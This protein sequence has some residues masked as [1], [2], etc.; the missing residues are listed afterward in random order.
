MGTIHMIEASKHIDL[1]NRIWEE[2]RM[3]RQMNEVL[4][5]QS[6]GK[7]PRQT[8]FEPGSITFTKA[9]LERVQHP[10][11]NPLVIQLRMNGYDV[12]KILVN[13]GSSIEMMYY[14]LF[15]QLKLSQSDLK[16]VQALLVGFNAQSH[17]PL[18]TVTL[19]V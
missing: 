5:V 17:W 3:I 11:F 9:D 14:D 19:K 10:H 2:I 8:M 18:G 16:L 12:R 4:S 15:K 13:R 7:K 1:E 6:S